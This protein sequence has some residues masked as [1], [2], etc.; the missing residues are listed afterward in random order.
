MLTKITWPS[1]PELCSPYCHVFGVN[2]FVICV[3]CPNTATAYVFVCVIWSFKWRQPRPL[4]VKKV[5]C[6]YLDHT[7]TSFLGHISFVPLRFWGKLACGWLKI[8]WEVIW[9]C[10]SKQPMGIYLL[11]NFLGNYVAKKSQK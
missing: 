5:V 10:N 8:A 9:K 4:K 1:P 7:M 11:G 2:T 6:L 3:G